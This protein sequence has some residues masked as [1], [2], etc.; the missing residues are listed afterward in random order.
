MPG[1]DLCTALVYN[2]SRHAESSHPGCGHEAAVVSIRD[3]I[4]AVNGGESTQLAHYVSNV[5]YSI[6]SGLERKDIRA[7]NEA[8]YSMLANQSLWDW[9]GKTYTSTSDSSCA[10][11]DG[12]MNILLVSM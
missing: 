9:R 8:I 1:K 5:S 3:A 7:D 6:S 11:I 10:V 2:S 4:A 12:I